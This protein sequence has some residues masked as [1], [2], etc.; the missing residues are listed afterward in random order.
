MALKELDGTVRLPNVK[1]ADDAIDAPNGQDGAA[2]FVPVV[3]Q[4][5]GR[6]ESRLG[7]PRHASCACGRR[8]DR[9]GHLQ[10]VACA[11]WCAEVPEAELAVAG[12][13][14]DDALGVWGPLGAVGA[15]VCGQGE[16]AAFPL[17]VPDLDGAVP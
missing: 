17:R 16:D 4:G 2:V 5:F 11:G 12:H 13:G 10:V 8:M 14:G 9:H 3:G 1:D 15:A 7:F 6:R